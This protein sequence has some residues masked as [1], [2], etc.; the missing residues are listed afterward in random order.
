MII[1]A[2]QQCES[3]IDNYGPFISVGQLEMYRF[4]VS[5]MA[6]GCNLLSVFHILG[7]YD[8]CI[9]GTLTKKNAIF[10][11]HNYSRR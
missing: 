1:S 6:H 10:N 9:L 3:V 11:S 4:Q 7:W 2:V 5:V 8:M